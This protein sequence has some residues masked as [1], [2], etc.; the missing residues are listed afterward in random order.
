MPECRC[1]SVLKDERG[2]RKHLRLHCKIACITETVKV[3]CNEC[4]MGFPTQQGL[5]QHCRHT[6][7]IIYN[8]ECENLAIGARKNW[9]ELEEKQLA[10]AEVK[11][12]HEPST[13][14]INEALAVL[15]DRTA[16][17]IKCRRR[18][19]RYRHLLSTIEKEPVDITEGRTLR[20]RPPK[21]ANIDRPS[22]PDEKEFVTPPSSP[23]TSSFSTNS[24]FSDLSTTS[25]ASGE[26]TSLSSPNNSP[27]RSQGNTSASVVSS[28]L[29]HLTPP[30]L[31]NNPAPPEDDPIRDHL[32]RLSSELEEADPLLSKLLL[33]H[34]SLT[35]EDL[36]SAMLTRVSEAGQFMLQRKR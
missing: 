14:P 5:A 27:T 31:P 23:N 10:L 11:L 7:P 1:G 16:E 25:T 3:N 6:H 18:L 8:Q 19:P 26:S 20:A 32:I 2:L 34:D 22:T 15:F 17:A 33:S 13:L 30:V 28:A 24:A 35:P 9:T 21:M 12:K 4:G 36:I 29:G